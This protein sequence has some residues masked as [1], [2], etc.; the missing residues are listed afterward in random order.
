MEPG[1][2]R[3]GDLDVHVTVSERRRTVGLTVE[4]DATVTAVVPPTVDEATLSRVITARQPWL[5]AKLRERAETGTPRPPR[6]YVSGEGFPY[7]GRSYRLLVV[8][9][10]VGVV[11]LKR[12][13]LVLRRDCL[14]DAAGHLVRWYRT[15]GEQWLRK[16]ITPWAQRMEVEVATLNVLPLGYRWGS[17]SPDGRVN[18]HWASMQLPR[19]LI[20]YVLVHELAHV[21]HPDHSREFW[22]AVDRAMPGW[23]AR[24]H[25]LK[26][27]G[28]DL[29]LPE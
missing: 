16:R 2:L 3:V 21:L 10:A 23:E 15:A 8:E 13:R 20:D 24:R 18:I 1:L 22:R 29:W 14:D 6:E 25:R 17:C 9:D 12:G 27:V 11:R 28:A 26:R 19:D 5:F 7:L 4:R